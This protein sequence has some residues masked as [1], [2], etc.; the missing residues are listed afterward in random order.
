MASPSSTD[1]RRAERRRATKET[2]SRSRSTS[3]APGRPVR[4]RASRSS[5][6]CSTSSAGTA[7][8][9][10]TVHGH[11]RPRGRRPPHASRT[12]A[13]RSARRFA[14][15]LG[16]KAGV[17]RFASIALPLDEALVDVALDLSGR[18]LPPLRRRPRPTPPRS[19]AR[20][21]TP[22]SP[23]SS[24]GPSCTPPRITLH[25]ALRYGAEHPPHP[26]G[27]LQGASPVR[28]ATRSRIEGRRGP[29]DQGRALSGWRGDR[30][31]RLRDRQPP[32][33]GEG[34]RAPRRA[35]PGWSTTPT[36]PP[37]PTAWCCPASGPSAPAPRRLEASGLEAVVRDG[38]DAGSPSSGSA[39]ASS[40]SSSVPRRARAPPGLG[41]APG[42]GA[43]R[44]PATE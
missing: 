4:R 16:D 28:F 41:I 2:T 40:C 26:R 10:S 24:G 31:P 27:V 44:S 29:L 11:G 43:R 1:G 13:S 25:V 5:T 21:S 17:R 38:I 18:A 8:S 37:G 6:T 35:T 20:R 36:R 39:S 42:R 30:R 7:G 22:S 33:G 12:P 23:R 32:L 14:E 34:A 19:A 3:T 9:T 15:A